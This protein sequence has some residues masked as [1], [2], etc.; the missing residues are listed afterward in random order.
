MIGELEF[1][2]L[3]PRIMEEVID[4]AVVVEKEDHLTFCTFKVLF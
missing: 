1:E 2:I 3:V 4:E